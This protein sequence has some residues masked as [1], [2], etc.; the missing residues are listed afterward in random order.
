MTANPQRCSRRLLLRNAAAA[1]DW[2][3]IPG[4]LAARTFGR[5]IDDDEFIQAALA[6]QAPWSVSGDRD[7]LELKP[8]EGLRIITPADALLLLG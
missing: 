4:G 7:L 5:D 2:V 1:A 6:A 8:I 3:D